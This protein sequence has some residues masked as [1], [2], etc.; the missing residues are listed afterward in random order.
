MILKFDQNQW[1]VVGIFSICMVSVLQFMD[2]I[3]G[4]TGSLNGAQELGF[5][6]FKKFNI[7]RPPAATEGSP[8][9]PG[10][11]SACGLLEVSACRE[12]RMWRSRTAPSLTFT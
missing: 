12:F 7:P 6:W 9:D 5:L 1:I 10:P 11:H 2:R 4:Q 3:L 8:L